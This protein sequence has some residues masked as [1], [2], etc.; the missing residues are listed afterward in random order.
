[1]AFRSG[2]VFALWIFC[3]L[4]IVAKG[5]RE[6]YFKGNR[7]LIVESLETNCDHDYVEY[8]QKVTN[9][10]Q[11]IHTFRVTKLVSAFSIDVMEKVKKTHRIF[12]KTKISRGCDFINNPMPYKVFGES[13]KKM[14][15]NGSFIKCPVKPKIYYINTEGPTSVIP[16]VHSPGSFQLRMRIKVPE[17][18]RPFAMEMLWKF[19][20]VYV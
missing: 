4:S 11:H 3:I 6:V 1:M 15:V 17:S 14:A 13:F 7:K 2:S 19:K 8:F 20:I 18:S 5:E 12:Y 9:S 16:S 10:S